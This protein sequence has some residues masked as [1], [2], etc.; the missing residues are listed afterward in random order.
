MKSLQISN[1]KV[2][3]NRV[4]NSLNPYRTMK[5]LFSLLF[6]ASTTFAFADAGWQ[7]DYQKALAQARTQ[8][9]KVLLNFTG[10]DWCGWCIKLKKEVF[11]QPAFKDFAEKNLV[12]VEVDFPRSKPLSDAVK[13][14]NNA[15]QKE[16]GIDGFPTLVLLDSN[17]KLVRKSSGYMAGGAKGVIDWIQRK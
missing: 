10:S 9:K 13:K 11:D 17:G 16:Y 4:R 15:L 12:L 6:I 2:C 3:A 8:N 1:L 7:T 14:Q 5:F